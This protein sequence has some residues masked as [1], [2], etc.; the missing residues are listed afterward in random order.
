[1]IRNPFFISAFI[2]FIYDPGIKAF[3]ELSGIVS[4]IFGVR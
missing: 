4:L 2:L 3:I 1:M